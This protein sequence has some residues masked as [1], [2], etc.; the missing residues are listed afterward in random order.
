M[1]SREDNLKKLNEKKS[2]QELSVI[3]NGKTFIEILEKTVEQ[4]KETVGTGIE[5][6]NTDDLLD[7]LGLLQNFHHEVKELKQSISEIKFPSNVEVN[8]LDDLI[9]SAKE[10]IKKPDPT[11]NIEKVDISPIVKSIV[12]L[13]QKIEDQTITPSK[14]IGDYMPMRRVIQ[15]GNRLMW[16]DSFYTGGG[17][18]AAAATSSS[19]GGS[20]DISTLSTAAKQDTG[21]TSLASIVTALAGTLTTKEI[22]SATPTQSSV[23]GNASNVTLLASNASRLGATIFNDS[24]A[25]LYVKLGATSSTTSFSI[26]LS[27]DDYYEIPFGYTGIIDGI[28]ASATG[29]A[30]ITE[31]TA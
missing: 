17:G 21:N 28:W 20:I 10:L 23:A 24:T 14:D 2:T 1:M 16:D 12:E 13:T 31:I 26:K 19:G 18:G 29:N 9:S 25:F 5:L 30:R 3:T 7:Q 4:F 11:F 8:G 6:K 15:V 22:R 27:Q